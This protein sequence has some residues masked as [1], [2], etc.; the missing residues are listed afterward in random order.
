MRI[1]TNKTKLWRLARDYGAQPPPL[2]YTR[3]ICYGGGSY[4]LTWPGGPKVYLT[5][6]LGRPV[7]LI[8]E[9]SH[10]LTRYARGP[11]G[12]RETG[13]VDDVGQAAAALAA[14]VRGPGVGDLCPVPGSISPGP[15]GVPECPGIRK[16]PGA[17]RTPGA[18]DKGLS[19][20][21]TTV[22]YHGN[23][24]LTRGNRI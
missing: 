6:V 18:A 5:A 2:K 9:K 12:T 17:L 13:G 11:G 10:G 8:G 15:G 16:A 4:G 23:M 19:T 14:P 1:Q 22:L 20:M 3:R 21:R 7:L 24:R